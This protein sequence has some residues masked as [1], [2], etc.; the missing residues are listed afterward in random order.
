MK[1]NGHVDRITT[2]LKE[3]GLRMTR[4]RGVILGQLTDADGY[5]SAEE[6]YHNL[7][8]EYP[9]IGLATVYRTI[10]L[11]NKMG[12]VNRLE[13]GEGKARYELAETEHH[14]LIVCESCYSVIKYSDFTTRE[15]DSFADLEKLVGET[16][17]YSI[18]RHMVQ[19]YG[20]CPECLKKQKNS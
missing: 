19:Y 13:T 9:G 7:H 15:K 17:H 1:N 12:I 16:Y 18:N 11:L 8:G 20:I 6:I 10:L 3:K 14:H 4:P 2:M 5:R